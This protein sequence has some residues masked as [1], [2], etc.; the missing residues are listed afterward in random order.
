VNQLT[1]SEQFDNAA[2][3]PTGVT[4]AAPTKV[5]ASELSFPAVTAAGDISILYNQF[6]SLAADH[7]GSIELKAKA[8]GDVGKKIGI[9]INDGSATNF[10][11]HTLTSDWVRVTVSEVTSAS[12][13]CRFNAGVLGSTY[14]GQT[15]GA[16][17]VNVRYADCR[18][19]NDGVGIPAY[20]RINA[21][22][23]Y[24]TSGFPLYLK[25]DGVDD[26]LSTAGIDFS[27]TD[28]MSLFAGVRKLSDATQG[29]IAELSASSTTNNGAF[30]LLG[31]ANGATG[32]YGWRSKGTVAANVTATTFTAPL[33]NVLTG[34]GDVAGDSSILRLNGVAAT[35]VTTDQGT[36]TFGNYPLYIGRRA[37]TSL[38]ANIRLYSLIVRGAQSTPEQIVATE[39]WVNGKTGAY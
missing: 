28:K 5:S 29:M 17:T 14:G 9:Y 38:Q 11:F 34:I 15:Q 20:Q 7:T 21:A 32:D 22:T 26:S 25:F 6:T 12:A 4:I 24:D 1:F 35:P 16:V 8:A 36:G 37:G 31:P 13:T 23:D 39:T 33:T 19:T 3:A 18:V 10:V 2:W 30:Y 27:A